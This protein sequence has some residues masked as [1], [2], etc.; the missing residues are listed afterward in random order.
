MQPEEEEEL[1][2]GNFT[3]QMQPEEEEELIQG[4]FTAQMQPEEEEE[5]IQGKFSVQRYPV[6]AVV[7][8][9]P[10]QQKPNKAD[11]NRT[12]M[13]D[14]VKTRMEDTFTAD[15]SDVRVHPNSGKATEVGA[16]AYTQ[17]TDVHFAPGKYKPDSSAGQQLLGHELT[18][19]IQQSQGRV[20][21]TGKIAG[22][23]VNDSPG[24]EQEA[25][26]MGGKSIAG[27]R[28]ISNSKRGKE[29]IRRELPNG[30]QPLAKPGDQTVQLSKQKVKFGTFQTE[31]Q[32]DVVTDVTKNADQLLYAPMKGFFD[33]TDSSSGL[34]VGAIM[35]LRFIP[36]PKLKKI[37]KTKPPTVVSLVQTVKDSL[38]VGGQP[39]ER[40]AAA[41]DLR[42][43]GEGYVID[44]TLYEDAGDKLVNLDPRYTEKR[45]DEKAPLSKKG[46]KV[47]GTAGH[48]VTSDDS[49]LWSEGAL[50]RDN[51]GAVN[52]KKLEGGMEFEVSA[53]IEAYDETEDKMKHFFGGSV[54]WG[55]KA[56][57]K[58]GLT[59]EIDPADIQVADEGEASE[60]FFK[61][62]DAWNQMRVPGK[63]GDSSAALSDP[64]KLPGKGGYEAEYEDRPIPREPVTKE[65]IKEI[66]KDD[67]WLAGPPQN[68]IRRIEAK[69]ALGDKEKQAVLKLKLPATG[70]VTKIAARKQMHIIFQ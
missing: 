27:K 21:P 25:D 60:I 66:I 13:P 11:E 32:T 68:L 39:V 50:L 52:P 24:L 42:Q 10:L 20:Q 45:L 70:I 36:N 51:P 12:G 29:P 18:H 55:W 7:D 56:T 31:E 14:S 46:G 26:E 2:Q 65:Q 58:D 33:P 35:K 44:Q 69:G 6:P 48:S 30:P 5:L 53:L 64:M 57:G 43:T 23:P 16:L 49:K 67:A 47:S 38:K 61:A 9:T 37:P 28:D 8:K 3:V 63:K 22:L 17:G 54:R 59:P 62:V 19:V 40:P 1:I 4:K 41:F 15:F 34:Q